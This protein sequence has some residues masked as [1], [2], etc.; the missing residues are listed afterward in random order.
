[1]WVSLVVMKNP[2]WACFYN[3]LWQFDSQKLRVA[4]KHSTD[5]CPV[6]ICLRP[7]LSP[8]GTVYLCF[9]AGRPAMPIY[10]A[11]GYHLC[12]WG[13]KTSDSTWE[14]VK[15]MRN[16]QIPQVK[17]SRCV[18]FSVFFFFFFSLFWNNNF[19]VCRTS[20]GMT[21]T[22]WTNLWTSRLTQQILPLFLTWL[23]TSTLMTSAT[24]WSWYSIYTWIYFF[25]CLF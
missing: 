4:V 20:S 21:S 24:S 5:H 3:Q 15:S 17:W 10:W 8:S 11:L 22:T 2:C 23:R 13:Y 19:G 1:M 12:R 6:H 14:V 7:P 9:F 16:Y 18:S 25:V